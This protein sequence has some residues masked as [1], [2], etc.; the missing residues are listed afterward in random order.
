MKNFSI[1]EE[2]LMLSGHNACM[3][4]GAALAMRF[5]LKALGKDTIITIPASCWAVIPGVYPFR[6]LEIP[7]LYTPFEVTGAAISGLREALDIQNSEHTN[8]VGF[9]GDGGTA[10]IGLQSLSGA[11]ERGHNVFY[12][13]YDNEAYM[14]TGVQRSSSTPYGAWTT[15]TQVGKYG[16]WKKEQKKNIVEIMVAHRIPYTATASIAYPE[17]LIN[18]I[19]KAKSIH[20]QKFIH[21]FATCPV[22]WKSPPNKSVEIAKLAVE[23]GIFPLYEV[24]NGIYTITHKAKKLIPVKEYLKPQMRFK[25]LNNSDINTIQLQIKQNYKILLEKERIGHKKHIPFI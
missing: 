16:D 7:L 14:N 3:G 24:V 22:G 12:I 8:V 6:A 18:K 10:D 25:H 5:V 11:V 2:E 13:M 20:G 23:S 17:D 21:L 4:C 9:A 1:P 19:K 15:T